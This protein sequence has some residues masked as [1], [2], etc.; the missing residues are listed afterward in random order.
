MQTNLC[1]LMQAENKT[2]VFK[3]A[4]NHYNVQKQCF[5]KAMMKNTNGKSCEFSVFQ[6]IHFLVIG[7]SFL[8]TKEN[9]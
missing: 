9:C 5:C 1:H 6:K 2:K 8:F 3:S 7:L 4:Q